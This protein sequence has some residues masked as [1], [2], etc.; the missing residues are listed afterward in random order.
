MSRLSFFA[1]LGVLAMTALLNAADNKVLT[2][3]MKNI[4]GQEVDLGQKYNGKVVLV[5]N[6]ASRCGLT[7]QYKELQALHTKF[8]DKGLAVVG[9]PCNQFGSQE[10]GTEAEIKTFCT[11]KY[12]VDFDMMSKVEV[13]GDDA[14]PLYKQLTA[15]ETQPTGA[16]AISWNFEKFVI[17]KDGQ[18]AARFSPRTKPDAQEVLEVIEAELAK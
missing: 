18:I 12:A 1:I 14:C 6:V 7:N 13:N 15:A 2:G 10:P 4:D 8:A 17:G 3:T 11:T 5:V 9:F 16:G